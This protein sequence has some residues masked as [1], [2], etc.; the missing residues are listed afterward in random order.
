MPDSAPFTG[1]LRAVRTQTTT[2]L[3]LAR[4][5]ADDQVAQLSGKAANWADQAGATVADS[6]DGAAAA[7][8]RWAGELSER[9]V[10]AGETLSDRRGSRD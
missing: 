8:S 1:L 2:L 3:G 7:A 4:E 6:L 5:Q 9:L 10:R